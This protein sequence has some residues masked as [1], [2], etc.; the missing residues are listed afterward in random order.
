MS[1]TRRFVTGFPVT[2]RGEVD[3]QVPVTRV[4]ERRLAL[5]K[6]REGLDGRTVHLY[7]VPIFFMCLPLQSATSLTFPHLSQRCVITNTDAASVRMGRGLYQAPPTRMQ[8]KTS[9]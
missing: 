6:T 3:A 7:V 5:F 9:V 1:G 4:L 8:R 2:E